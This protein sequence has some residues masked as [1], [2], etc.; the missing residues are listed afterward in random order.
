MVITRVGSEA[1]GEGPLHELKPVPPG[2]LYAKPLP[3]AG[4]TV[5]CVSLDTAR[6]LCELFRTFFAPGPA[7]PGP[8]DPAVPS[9]GFTTLSLQYAKYAKSRSRS[10]R[11]HMMH[12]YLPR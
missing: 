1:E 3:G 7:R 6:C 9:Y 8:S 10:I 2:G 5:L 12:A 4:R 11:R